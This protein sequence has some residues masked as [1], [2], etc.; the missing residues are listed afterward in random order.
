[1]RST[2]IAPYRSVDSIF[3]RSCAPVLCRDCLIIESFRT[4]CERLLGLGLHCGPESLAV[5]P[6][7]SRPNFKVVPFR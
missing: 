3:D 5:S 1:M 7:I 4:D 6:D 2:F